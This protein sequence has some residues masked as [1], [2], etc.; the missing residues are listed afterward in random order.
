M[1]RK[2]QPRKP[3]EA[4]TEDI[5]SAFFGSGIPRVEALSPGIVGG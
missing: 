1:E 3:I 4:L 5:V 2:I